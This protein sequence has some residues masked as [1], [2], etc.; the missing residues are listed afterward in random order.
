MTERIFVDGKEIKRPDDI[1]SDMKGMPYNDEFKREATL[2]EEIETL[3]IPDYVKERMLKKLKIMK[4]ES[5]AVNYCNEETITEHTVRIAD[6]FYNKHLKPYRGDPKGPQGRPGN[7][8]LIGWLLGQ[9]GNVLK[10]TEETFICI[11]KMLYDAL[12]GW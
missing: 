6:D 3:E 10:G 9:R 11:P 12:I 2:Q 4:A 1:V 7:E 5:W 8:S